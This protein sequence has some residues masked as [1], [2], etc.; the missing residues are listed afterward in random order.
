MMSELK[1]HKRVAEPAVV[2]D[3][4]I[5]AYPVCREKQQQKMTLIWILKHIPILVCTYIGSSAQNQLF[6]RAH[7]KS[8]WFYLISLYKPDG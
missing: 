2:I 6:R 1:S 4:H 3:V 5:I 7:I 8:L